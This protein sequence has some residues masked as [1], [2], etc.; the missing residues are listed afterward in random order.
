L[1]V[2]LLHV[3]LLVTITTTTA[4]GV[5]GPVI[6][7]VTTMTDFQ[8]KANAHNR[9]SG[10]SAPIGDAHKQ[11]LWIFD[12]TFTNNGLKSATGAWAMDITKPWV[13]T[14][15]VD[16]LG[17]PLQFYPFT[18]EELAYNN[19]QQ[20]VPACCHN[21][22][23][24]PDN[25]RY[26]HCAASTDCHQRIAFWSERPFQ[27]NATTILM[28]YRAQYIGYAPWDFENI[29]MG[30]AYTKY[31][32]TVSERLM[33]NPTTPLYV[34]GADEPE[35]D[36]FVE[37]DGNVY[38]TYGDTTFCTSTM[39]M[40][41]APIKTLHVKTSYEYYTQ[42]EGSGVGWTSDVN[43]RKSLGNF[44]GGM[45]SCMWSDHLKSF[46]SFTLGICTGGTKA[47]F[48]T[49][50]TPW[51]PWSDATTIDFAPYGAESGSYAGEL[52]PELAENNTVVVSFFAP[53]D[54]FSGMIKMRKVTLG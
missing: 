29:G 5:P 46:L 52:H 37:Y 33:V 36:S 25:N 44:G 4:T 34:F 31:P 26:C 11:M 39:Y 13:L 19:K 35:W 50:P 53:A 16:S 30:F 51:G 24:C 48:R 12:D 54:N 6:K 22:T 27:I 42:K 3:I 41:R 9:D 18:S 40:A 21:Q 14:E 10:K 43:S 1:H 38:F 2:F 47:L 8:T 7:S 32:T 23:S 28:I 45:G 17:A 20:N 15:Q 49:A